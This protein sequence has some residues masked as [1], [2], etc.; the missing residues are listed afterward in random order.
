MYNPQIIVSWFR[1]LSVDFTRMI[2]MISPRQPSIIQRILLSLA[3]SENYDLGQPDVKKSWSQQSFH[4][5][6][7]GHKPVHVDVNNEPDPARMMLPIFKYFQPRNR[8][9]HN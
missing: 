9:E 7:V 2:I 1:S 4:E 6:T 8:Q 3:P 5:P